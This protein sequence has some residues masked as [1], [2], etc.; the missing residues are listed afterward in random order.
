MPEAPIAR[1][2]F[3]LE[4]GP[5]ER[6]DDTF[7]T[8]LPDDKAAFAYAERVVGELKE[9]GGYDD[10]DLKMVVKNSAGDVVRTIQF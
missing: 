10:P 7:G 2:F 4:Y 3:V 1:Y 6:H 8:A 5:N 9:A